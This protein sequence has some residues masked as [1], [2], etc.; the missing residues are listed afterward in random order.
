MTK[1]GS[2]GIGS[3]KML[4]EMIE[5]TFPGS[6]KTVTRMVMY[7]S[8]CGDSL[9]NQRS[10]VEHSHDFKLFEDVTVLAFNQS[11]Q[12]N[13]MMLQHTLVA[14]HQGTLTEIKVLAVP[15]IPRVVA[16]TVR[17]PEIWLDRLSVKEINTKGKECDLLI[18][19]DRGDL[20]PLFSS[21]I[22][23]QGEIL[24]LWISQLTGSYLIGG[25]SV[26]NLRFERS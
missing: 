13:P 20:Q 1:A 6:D 21:H 26:S 7:D 5:F 14:K 11:G 25:K 23:L 18:G 19:L 2:S 15:S 22:D 17:V 12:R 8:G 9:M 24:S 3:T 4:T 16:D 10:M